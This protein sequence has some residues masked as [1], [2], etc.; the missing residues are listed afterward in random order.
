MVFLGWDRS[1]QQFFLTVVELC[2][3]CDG[4]GEEPP[5][6]EVPCP[7]CEGEGIEFGSPSAQR[8]VAR[9]EDLAAELARIA[10]P[11]PTQVRADLEQDQRTNAGEIVH[12]YDS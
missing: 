2:K 11:F 12:D 6:S 10:I 4:V 9:L 8:S 1:L 7:A 3:R 5:N